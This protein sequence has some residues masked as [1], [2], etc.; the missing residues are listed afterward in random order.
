MSFSLKYGITIYDASY[1]ALAKTLN[2]VLYTADGKI[3][4]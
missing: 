3:V 4:I 2:D 1:V